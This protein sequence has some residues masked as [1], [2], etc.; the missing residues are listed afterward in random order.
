MAKSFKN[1]LQ[2]P[3]NCISNT[4]KY[5]NSARN[6]Q[7]PD[8]I[9]RGFVFRRITGTFLSQGYQYVQRCK[10]VDFYAEYATVNI[11]KQV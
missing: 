9:C 2:I 7:N 4:V 8:K 11:Y 10:F 6:N 5:Y 1:S 3:V